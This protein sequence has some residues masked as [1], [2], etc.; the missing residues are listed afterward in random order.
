MWIFKPL[1]L[2]R[3][4]F[5]KTTWIFWPV[6]LHQKITSKQRGF[7]DQQN[8]I[9]KSTW[10][11]LGYFDQRNYIEKVRWTGKRG[12]SS[13]FGLR[14]ID[15]ISTSHRRWFYVICPLAQQIL[16][17]WSEHVSSKDMVSTYHVIRKNS[18]AMFEKYSSIFIQKL[19]M[20]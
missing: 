3:K 5:V 20:Q 10:K 19:Y 18:F 8:Y 17:P 12:K 2:H 9:V 4:K 16:E 14:R 6:K 13:K 7:F 11:R 1:K 15:V